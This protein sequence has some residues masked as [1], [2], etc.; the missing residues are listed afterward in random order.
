MLKNLL[1]PI[2]FFIPLAL[3]QLTLI[4]LISIG[5]IA[6][7]LVFVLIAYFTLING[8]SFGTILGFILGFLLDLASGGLIGA[9]MFSFTI[10]AFVVGYFSNENKI[11]VNTKTFFFLIIVFICGSINAFIYALIS[12]LNTNV[13]LFILIF[14]EGLFPGLYTAFFG[15]SVIIFAPKKG[16]I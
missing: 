10:S 2:L 5:S 9:F 4:P 3:I 11:E 6:P 15:F 1:K 14:Q 12:N 8:Q 16:M 13:S 7:N